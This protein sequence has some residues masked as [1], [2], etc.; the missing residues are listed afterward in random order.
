VAN[1]GVVDL[2]LS[3]ASFKADK[4]LKKGDGAK[5][6]RLT[7]EL[8]QELWLAGAVAGV[9]LVLPRAAPPAKPSHRVCLLNGA[10]RHPQAGGC[11]RRWRPQ[12]RAVHTNPDRGRLGQVASGGRAQ[13]G[14]ARPLRRV[15][16]QVRARE[17]AGWH[18]VGQ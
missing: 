6:Q 17:E 5:R 10:H 16:P 14:G 4:E 15:P 18:K 11:Q 1:C 3:F 12:Q 7:G 2:I 13:R 9:G 8:L